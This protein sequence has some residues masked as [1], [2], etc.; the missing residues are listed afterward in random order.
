MNESISFKLVKL[1]W[2]THTIKFYRIIMVNIINKVIR[3]SK[4]EYKRCNKILKICKFYFYIIVI[5]VVKLFGK[6]NK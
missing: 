2:L 1:L 3:K 6:D 4:K 5:N